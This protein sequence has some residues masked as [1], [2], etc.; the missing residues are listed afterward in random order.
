MFDELAVAMCPLLTA[1]CRTV[2]WSH[3]YNNSRG[4]CHDLC[5]WRWWIFELHEGS[6]RDLCCAGKNSSEMCCGRPGSLTVILPV[7]PSA[8]SV[9]STDRHGWDYTTWKRSAYEGGAELYEPPQGKYPK[10]GACLHSH[11]S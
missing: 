9:S 2:M 11:S 1:R 6:Y 4:H 7:A 3:A 10:A 5:I 8:G